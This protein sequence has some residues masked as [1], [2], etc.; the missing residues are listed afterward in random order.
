MTQHLCTVIFQMCTYLLRIFS[1][2]RG[3]LFFWALLA[4]A[5]IHCGSHGFP[6]QTNV[7][8]LWRQ[9]QGGRNA[10]SSSIHHDQDNDH[11][12]HWDQ[13]RFQACQSFDVFDD[14]CPFDREHC[15]LWSSGWNILRDCLH[16]WAHI[17][18]FLLAFDLEMTVVFVHERNNTFKWKFLKMFL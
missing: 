13:L 7:R 11:L 6:Y 18:K 1:S 15:I 9:V 16:F 14:G 2:C 8:S 17:V 3:N 12:G 4:N 10:N 5:G